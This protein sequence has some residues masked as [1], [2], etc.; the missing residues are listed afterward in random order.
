MKV[1]SREKYSSQAACRKILVYLHENELTTGDKLPSH[2]ELVKELHVCHDTLS[3][4]MKWLVEEGVLSRRQRVGTVVERPYPTLP[5]R[6]FWRVGIVAP[7]LTSSYFISVLIH[8]IHRH[9]GMRG[10][11]DRVYMLSLNA[12]PSSERYPQDFSGLEEDLEAEILNA[13]IT[14]ARLVADKVPVCGVASLHGDFGVR[15]DHRRFAL[16][17]VAELRKAGYRRILAGIAP[18]EESF[19]YQ[20]TEGVNEAKATY[21]LGN[22]LETSICANGI[23]SG[24]QL[25][26]TILERPRS[27]KVDAIIV[28]DDITAQACASLLASE[29]VSLPMAVLTNVQIPLSFAVPVLRFALD[30]DELAKIGVELLL[31][32]LLRP[33]KVPSSQSFAPKF[34]PDDPLILSKGLMP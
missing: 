28:R 5:Q 30:V 19:G 34:Q 18:P 20:F 23:K 7:P 21:E 31:Q 9:L 6:S 32:K 1:R 22:D 8:C 26:R 14:P 17:A 2:A 11:S 12:A 10:F 24:Y 3:T 16:E 29:G 13:L 4:A 25:A 33:S 27:Q 15:I